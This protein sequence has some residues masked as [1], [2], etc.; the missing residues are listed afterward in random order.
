MGAPSLKAE[1]RRHDLSMKGPWCQSQFF[2]RLLVSCDLSDLSVCQLCTPS[3]TW[4]TC[5]GHW[6][7]HRMERGV[8]RFACATSTCRTTCQFR[9]SCVR[10]KRQDLPIEK[11]E[12][13]TVTLS[14][15]CDPREANCY[16]RRERDE[17]RRMQT[18]EKKEEQVRSR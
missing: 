1:R 5:S 4:K 11:S 9:Y 16:A 8:A 10:G 13:T 12:A 14:V 2:I 7:L 15:S 3:T 17:V 18:T 6:E